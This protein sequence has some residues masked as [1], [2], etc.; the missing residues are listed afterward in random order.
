MIDATEIYV[1]I[2]LYAAWACFLGIS[3]DM[4]SIWAAGGAALFW[5]L[6]PVIFVGHWLAGLCRD[7]WDWF[8]NLGQ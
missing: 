8:D 6:W 1:L 2:Y 5:P 7:A 4:D 3:D